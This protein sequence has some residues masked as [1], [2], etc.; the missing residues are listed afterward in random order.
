MNT[1]P[2]AYAHA[3]LV[4]SVALADVLTRARDTGAEV[5]ISAIIQAATPH[6]AP[7]WVPSF[8]DQGTVYA[9]AVGLCSGA[10]VPALAHLRA[11]LG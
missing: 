3:T 8:A 9:I 1:D 7:G 4:A 5:N 2:A 10:S 6:L 11:V